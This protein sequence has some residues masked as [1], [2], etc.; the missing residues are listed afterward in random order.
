LRAS[1]TVIR[2]FKRA[3]KMASLRALKTVG[4]YTLMMESAWRRRRLLILA[5]HG[6]SLCDEHEW[7]PELYMPTSALR[8]RLEILQARGCQLL[9]L[10]T[11]I[12]RLYA[13]T[14]PPR[15]VVVT[16]DDGYVDFAERA[17]P[18]L[19][20]FGVPAT[21]YLPTLHCGR[22]RPVFR[23]VVAYMLWKARGRTVD[24][25]GLLPQGNQAFAL[26]TQ[27]ERDRANAAINLT[28]QRDALSL[29]E[30]DQFAA[31]LAGRLGID[32]EAITRK[33][34]F[35]V[36]TPD[37]IRGVAREGISIELHTHTHRWLENAAHLSAE[38]AM[39][40]AAIQRITGTD[41]RH[42]C[43]PSGLYC[44]EFVQS[45]RG[46]DLISATTCDP[47]LA[48]RRN[49]PLLLPRVV[50]GYGRSRLEFEG[51]VTGATA[52]VSRRRS[53]GSP[54]PSGH[55]LRRAAATLVRHVSIRRHPATPF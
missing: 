51:W 50:D 6:I 16:F 15:S 45:L 38:I 26:A 13:D 2:S 18:L 40:R 9:P 29:V 10:N 37:E 17:F 49:D 48:S 12:E 53:Y 19:R 11:A 55:G 36:M 33:R 32:Y 46:A 34:L 5:Y 22:N 43:Y 42:F 7:N 25:S 1:P 4:G 41:A 8:S 24:F 23:L 52:L 14:L 30:K 3:L 21:V 44:A 20:H 31:A 54:E 27:A 35:T 39:N 28:A 47:G